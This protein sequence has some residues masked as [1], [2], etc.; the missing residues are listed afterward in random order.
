MVDLLQGMRN[1]SS[2]S[3]SEARQFEKKENTKAS[4]RVQEERR[5]DEVGTKKS[6][7]GRLHPDSSDS[8]I[9]RFPAQ[10]DGLAFASRSLSPKVMQKVSLEEPAEKKSRL[11]DSYERE[12]ELERQKYKKEEE[13]LQMQKMKQQFTYFK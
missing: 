8:E 9:R 7:Q 5:L 6:S 11:D 3:Q 10:A 4:D 1:T 2:S 13:F 12:R